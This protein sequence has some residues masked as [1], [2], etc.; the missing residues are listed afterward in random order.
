MK[1]ACSMAANF[2]QFSPPI[3]AQ[4]EPVQPKDEN[5]VITLK[6]LMKSSTNHLA[7]LERLESLIGELSKEIKDRKKEYQDHVEGIR[8][9][10]EISH[11]SV[12]DLP[13]E[14]LQSI[15]RHVLQDCTS[16][17][18]K[19][20]RI[21]FDLD[22]WS[23]S[24]VCRKWRASIHSDIVLWAAVPPVDLRSGGG[25]LSTNDHR[26]LETYLSRS[27]NSP[28]S[29]R[30]MFYHQNDIPPSLLATLSQHIIRA[31]ELSIT[32][33]FERLESFFRQPSVLSPSHAGL[34]NLKTL[35]MALF[36]RAESA[37]LPP[38]LQR[39]PALE[40]L[41]IDSDTENLGSIV[42]LFDLPWNQLTSLVLVGVYNTVVSVMQI[43]PLTSCLRHLELNRRQLW[44]ESESE[45]AVHAHW[46]HPEI[47]RLCLKGA[48]NQLLSSLDVAPKLEELSVNAVAP[49][50]LQDCL[51][52][53][54][55]TLT[56]CTFPCSSKLLHEVLPLIPGLQT[57]ELLHGIGD[58][59]LELLF[60]RPSDAGSCW[61]VPLLEVLVIHGATISDP[62][63]LE[64]AIQAR[65]S[66]PEVTPFQRIELVDIQHSWSES[67]QNLSEPTLD[68]VPLPYSTDVIAAPGYSFIFYRRLED[69][70]LIRIGDTRGYEVVR[71]HVASRGRLLL[72]QS[73]AEHP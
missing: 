51:L 27:G 33:P 43:L 68:R 60:T 16:V 24:W 30:F 58:E 66:A 22:L 55:R 18:L 59:D 13:A 6:S 45:E 37:N 35:K 7:H 3:P 8:C 38:L 62:I 67:F 14:L 61:L 34:V 4:P 2:I 65:Q 48:I 42:H 40:H 5:D 50:V 36:R 69:Y 39:L 1:S 29:M 11:P 72:T 12:N 10:L 53:L 64:N 26:I 63:Y 32:I 41:E 47:R 23:L 70:A 25:P 44:G 15:F 57:L 17:R 21:R 19:R 73:T 20:S 54:G 31:R 71:Q 28:I 9:R 56:R 46:G 49:I 52:R